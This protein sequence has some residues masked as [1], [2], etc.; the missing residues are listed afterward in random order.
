VSQ[1]KRSEE[2]PM[3]VSLFEGMLKDRHDLLHVHK[4]DPH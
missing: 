4:N 2:N 1:I 3:A